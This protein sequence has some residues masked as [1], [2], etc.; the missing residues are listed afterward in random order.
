MSK[1]RKKRILTLQF[2]HETNSFNP[3]LTDKKAFENFRFLEG[4]D[5][6]ASQRG[7]K[8]EMGAYLDVFEKRDD[9]ELV[10]TVGLCAMPRGK[11]TKDVYEYVYDKI[12][13]CLKTSSPF[14]AVLA[15]FHGAMVSESHADVEGDFYEMIRGLVGESVPIMS[16]LD[17]HANVTAKMAKYA[18][19]LVPYECYPHT[20]TYETGLTVARIME[21]TL[22]GKIK[23]VMAY[24]RIPFLMPLLSH[25]FEELKPLYSLTKDIQ[26]IDKVLSARFAHGFF[27][28]DIEEMGMTVMIVTDGDRALAESLAD[29]VANAIKERIPKLKCKYPSLDEALDRA[30]PGNTPL[31]LADASDNPGAGAHG[32][33]THILRRILERGITGAAVATILDPESVIKCERAGI[34]ATI[35]LDLGGWSDSSLSGG[36]LKVRAKVRTLTDGNYVYKGKMQH[37]LKATHGRAAVIEVAGN[38]VIVT[39]IPRQPFD[40][41]VFRSHGITPEEQKILVTKSAIHY[42]A[43][44]GTV[45]KEMI[46]L[47]L[48]GMAS[49]DPQNY[50]YKNWKGK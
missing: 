5:F 12:Y 22:D 48:Q 50:V 2:R 42:R 20:D 18:D 10:P 35:D 8:T 4:E 19:V 14:D 39:S 49:P 1:N 37:G 41:E 15:D 11:V 23:P 16:A 3:S 7:I 25:E 26:K 17:L 13:K 6:F 21:N 33:S 28:S 44:Y 47:A 27:A 43:S 31:V 32:D 29:E 40:L 24:R 45:A 46:T 36:P 34:G 38:T 30:V 9:V